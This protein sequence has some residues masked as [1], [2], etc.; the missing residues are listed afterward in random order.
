MPATTPNGLPYPLGTDRVMDG[1]DAI[2]ALAT[3]I[4]Y[5]VVSG[6]VNFAATPTAPVAVTFPAGLFT[7]APHVSAAIVTTTAW[8]GQ[9]TGVTASG[10]NLQAKS[11][12]G[13]AGSGTATV[14]AFAVQLV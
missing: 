5:C 13:A 2:K 7:A 3:A 4:R 11:W 1:D 6:T 12:S 9:A 8:A 10:C 14:T